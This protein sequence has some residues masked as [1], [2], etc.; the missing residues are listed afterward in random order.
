MT[1]KPASLFDWNIV[2][3]AIGPVR[4]RAH[5]AAI[6]TRAGEGVDGITGQPEEVGR[7]VDVGEEI[8]G[9]AYRI[10]GVVGSEVPAYPIRLRVGVRIVHCVNWELKKIVAVVVR[11]HDR[12][13]R[14]PEL[15][16]VNEV[17]GCVSPKRNK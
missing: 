10:V 15:H 14:V 8:T 16:L 11:I 6:I 17:G 3:P 7:Q 12:A 1:Q 2:G 5:V 13:A 4:R 9:P